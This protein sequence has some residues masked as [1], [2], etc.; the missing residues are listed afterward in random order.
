MIVTACDTR[1]SGFDV[2]LASGIDDRCELVI[3]PAREDLHPQKYPSSTRTRFSIASLTP[4][5]YR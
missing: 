3:K 1:L 2:S 5:P 4:E